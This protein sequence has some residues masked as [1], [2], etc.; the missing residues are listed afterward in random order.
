MKYGIYIVVF[1]ALMIVLPKFGITL[2]LTQALDEAQQT[3]GG[4]IVVPVGLGVFGWGY[5]EDRDQ[6]RSDEAMLARAAARK[7]DAEFAQFGS[8]VTPAGSQGSDPISWNG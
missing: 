1:G 6:K 2:V 3:V 4:A 7:A 8:G 5:V